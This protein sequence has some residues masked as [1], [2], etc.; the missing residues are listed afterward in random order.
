MSITK[1][2]VEK[3]AHLARLELTQNELEKL[4]SQLQG[5]LNFIDQLSKLDTESVSP[6]SHILPITNVLREDL[7]RESIPSEKALMNAPSKDGN[8]FIV[9]KVIE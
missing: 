4:S 3:V 5:I 2:T 6:M 7:L 9:P 8:F 1:E